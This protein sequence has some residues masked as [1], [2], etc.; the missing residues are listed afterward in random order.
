[1]KKVLIH[2]DEIIGPHM[3]GAGIRY[4]EIAEQLSLVYEVTLASPTVL[5][6]AK[7]KFSVIKR[8]SR[9]VQSFYRGYDVVLTP[10]VLPALALAARRYG[11][12]LICDLYDP[13]IFEN[14]EALRHLDIGTQKRKNSRFQA[15]LQL[16]IH[17]ADVF[18]CASSEQ[19]D[20]WMGC[21]LAAGRI[22]PASYIKDPTMSGLVDIVPFGIK[23]ALPKKSAGGFRQKYGLTP[24]DILLLWGGGIW[25]W[26]DP[27]TLIEAMAI[28]STQRSDIKL[29]FMFNKDMESTAPQNTASR[30]AA[31]L[32]IKNSLINN[33]VFFNEDSI[34]YDQLQNFFLD[35]D[36]GVSCHLDHL[37]TRYAYRT[38]VLY[39]LG[40]GLPVISTEGDAMAA[41]IEKHDLG[42]VVPY[43]DAPALAAAIL[44]LVNDSARRSKISSSID[45]LRQNLSWNTAVRPLHRLI[46]ENKSFKP[47]WTSIAP[48]IGT[49][50]TAASIDKA[51]SKF[52]REESRG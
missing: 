16:A 50:Y 14:L 23:A 39:Y 30:K 47:N 12:K 49:S 13:V 28:I 44:N 7:Q 38:R 15:E 35:G 43:Q 18:I 33:S 21:L 1:M 10:L 19:R 31:E 26:F 2:C 8:A 45:S 24:N 20:L 34:E 41:L 6:L 9:P 5:P 32:A 3:S 29:V 37:E 42:E 46:D 40:A 48:R 51:L 17:T 36:I 4:W 11:F 22:T 27:L 25:N 52:Q